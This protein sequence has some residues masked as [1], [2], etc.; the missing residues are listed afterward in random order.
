[1]KHE[2]EKQEYFALVIKLSV[3][4]QLDVLCMS[5]EEEFDNNFDAGDLGSF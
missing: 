5:K 3:F 2:M 4:N 1:M